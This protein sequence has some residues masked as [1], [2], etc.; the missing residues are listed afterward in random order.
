MNGQPSSGM[1]LCLEPKTSAY[2]W[3]ASR[4]LSEAVQAHKDSMGLADEI[5]DF[6]KLDGRE[7]LNLEPG[8]SERCLL[9]H[10]IAESRSRTKRHRQC[11]R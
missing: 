4:I 10:A 2:S 1:S 3:S 6:E 7:A 11:T 8:M 9:G 5:L